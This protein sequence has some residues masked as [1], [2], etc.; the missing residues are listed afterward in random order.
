MHTVG[1]YPTV[2]LVLDSVRYKGGLH[3]ECSCQVATVFIDVVLPQARRRI[4]RF[5]RNRTW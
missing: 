4:G 3:A 1:V 2:P 5:F